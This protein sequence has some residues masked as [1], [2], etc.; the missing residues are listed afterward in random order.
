M[1]NLQCDLTNPC[2]VWL[3]RMCRGAGSCGYKPTEASPAR[4]PDGDLAWGNDV[5]AAAGG[6]TR[7]MDKKITLT[8][9]GGSGE[10]H[11]GRL[12][13]GRRMN[14]SHIEAA[15]GRRRRP[16]RILEFL[17]GRAVQ[18]MEYRFVTCRCRSTRVRKAGSAP[19][20]FRDI[21]ASWRRS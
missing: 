15:F 8:G 21:S 17:T 11:F 14:T 5:V 7:A 13:L 18:R 10:R 3:N 2:E 4:K 16:L 20:M 19:R 6:S 12:M 9:G 1:R